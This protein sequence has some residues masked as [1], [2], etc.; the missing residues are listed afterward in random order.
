MDKKLEKQ[1]RLEPIVNEDRFIYP[2]K[3]F[4]TAIPQF[5]PALNWYQTSDGYILALEMLGVGEEDVRLEIS[6]DR[7]FVQN[8]SS[9][10]GLPEDAVPVT[11]EF[12]PVYFKRMIQLPTGKLDLSRI[13]WRLKNGILLIS[14][15]FKEQ[16][17]VN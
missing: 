3:E 10:F 12:T 5:E 7:L 8:V 14:L 11:V 13:S 16:K 1:L 6:E 17:V 15:P 2:E 9:Q 4:S